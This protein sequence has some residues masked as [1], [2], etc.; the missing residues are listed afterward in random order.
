MDH[1]ALLLNSVGIAANLP[2]R[3]EEFAADLPQP[4]VQMVGVGKGRKRNRGKTKAA[5]TSRKRNR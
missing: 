3:L 5:K 2:H 1:H 4:G